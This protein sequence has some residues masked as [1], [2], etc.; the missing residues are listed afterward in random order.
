MAEL[1]GASALLAKRAAQAGPASI[2]AWVGLLAL[3]AILAAVFSGLGKAVPGAAGAAGYAT[4]G[5]GHRAGT[6]T[7]WWF[8][9]GVIT[10]DPADEA[11]IVAGDVITSL[12]STTVDTPSAL[13]AALEGFH[14]GDTVQIAWT[15]GTGQSHTASVQLASGPPA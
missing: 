3:S 9:A 2:L 7:R 12:G 5:L 1:H 13:T 6:V 4:A 14:P 11:G 8:L 15:D 10:G